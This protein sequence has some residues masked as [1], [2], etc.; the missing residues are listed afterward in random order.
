MTIRHFRTYGLRNR[1]LGLCVLLTFCFTL[2]PV[3]AQEKAAPLPEN[4]QTYVLQVGDEV[5][6][7]IQPRRE[8]DCAGT[9]APDGMLHLK[10]IAPVKAAGMSIA[11]LQEHV[12]KE[13]Q[14][15]LKRPRVTVSLIKLGQPLLRPKV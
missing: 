12:R 14:K 11:Q 13:M 1:I 5:E 4:T 6:V 15:Q 7:S 8:Y 9:V 3:A 10:S 2:R